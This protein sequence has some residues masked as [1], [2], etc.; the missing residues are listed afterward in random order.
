MSKSQTFVRATLIF[1]FFVW[2]CKTKKYLEKSKSCYVDTGSFIVYIKAD[3]IYKNI[4][5]DIETTFDTSNYKL[6]GPF[7][8]VKT[9]KSNHNL[10]K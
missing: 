5:E 8:K 3:Y 9:K 6:D 1:E 4:A 10:E 2:L 7:S